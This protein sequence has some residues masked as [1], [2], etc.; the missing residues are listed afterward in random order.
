MHLQPTVI[1]LFYNNE[2]SVASFS[3]LSCGANNV[4]S[5][6]SIIS[7][8]PRN[9]T[10]VE[11]LDCCNGLVLLLTVSQKKSQPFIKMIYVYN[12][13]TE[14]L[15]VLM[16][17]SKFQNGEH[18]CFSLA[19]DNH[20]PSLLHLICFTCFMKEDVMLDWIDIFSFEEGKCKWKH[21]KELPPDMMVKHNSKGTFL[22]GKVHRI[23]T[24]N[25][26]KILSID[27]N[28]GSFQV[29]HLPDQKNLSLVEIGQSQGLLH[30]MSVCENKILSI[31]VLKSY[32]RQEWTL[33]HRL[34]LQQIYP[35]NWSY[36]DVIDMCFRIYYEG[37]FSFHPLEDVIFMPLGYSG[38]F[39][40]DLSSGKKE[41]LNNLGRLGLFGFWLYMP[42][43]SIGMTHS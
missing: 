32:S 19:V 20:S 27:P 12:P 11:V 16:S 28:D 7:A 22:D 26:N 40:F 38:L 21:G 29:I 34:S 1:G 5:G 37:N 13:V 15:S 4:E 3:Y 14:S 33:K 35:L 9:F 24:Q 23:T 18:S 41:E 6:D 10:S 39:K 30:C 31:W 2:R 17:F 43:Y 25:Q 8:L 42:F 36:H